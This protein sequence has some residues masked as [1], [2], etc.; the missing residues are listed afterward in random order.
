MRSRLSNVFRVLSILVVMQA[1]PIFAQESGFSAQDAPDVLGI[2]LG[3]NAADI[4]AFAEQNLSDYSIDIHTDEHANSG[5]AYTSRVSLVN[6][7]SSISIL[8]TGLFSGNRAYALL[9]EDDYRSNIDSAVPF[10]A[11]LDAILQK[12][13]LPTFSTA[14]I[15][16]E[17]LYNPH[18]VQLASDEEILE[19]LPQGNVFTYAQL[20]QTENSFSL[21]SDLN[22]CT[23]SADDIRSNRVEVPETPLCSAALSAVLRGRRDDTIMG[24]LIA[25]A[26]YRLLD[27]SR[28][29]DLER[30]LD[31]LQT[32]TPTGEAPKL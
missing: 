19:L 16:F 30:D 24:L 25:M 13:G 2:Q 1:H 20:A 15:G 5:E 4:I 21:I 6:G 22:S 31:A 32:A 10:N 8:F 14:G 17:Y 26:D 9:R 27:S 28:Q 29:I 11:T 12:Y 3:M 18:R 7:G 23:I